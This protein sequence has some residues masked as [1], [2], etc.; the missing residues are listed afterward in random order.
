MKVTIT[1]YSSYNF[2]E[3]IQMKKHLMLSLVI[4]S[5]A[6]STNNYAM[7]EKE[8]SVVRK[9]LENQLHLKIEQHYK[10]FKKLFPKYVES[11]KHEK[12]EPE[13]NEEYQNKIGIKFNYGVLSNLEKK[14]IDAKYVSLVVLL[15]LAN[16]QFPVIEQAIC[17][18]E[19]ITK[20]LKSVSLQKARHFYSGVTECAHK[21][22]AFTFTLSREQIE[23]LMSG[24]KEEND[25]VA[26]H[27]INDWWCIIQ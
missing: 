6:V 8:L 18:D 22:F 10:E 24:M 26:Y 14:S 21:N 17:E 3:G 19:I 2:P 23:T 7:E 27:P 9:P 11:L 1:Y 5:L 16:K 25:L 13:N 4:G 15:H 20:F 12:Y